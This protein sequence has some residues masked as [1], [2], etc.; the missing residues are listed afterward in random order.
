VTL[1]ES[2][3][4]AGLSLLILSAA[5]S[6]SFACTNDQQC[7]GER[8]CINHE[9]TAAPTSSVTNRKCGKDIDCPGEEVCEANQCR[10]P[11]GSSTPAVSSSKYPVEIKGKDGAPMRLVPAGKFIM[12]SQEGRGQIYLKDFYMDVYEVTKARFLTFLRHSGYKDG[13]GWNA[14]LLNQELGKNGGQL[15]HDSAA[16]AEA[17]A[18]CQYYGKRLPTDD[19]W[20]KAARGTDGRDYPWGDEDPTPAHAAFD[21]KGAPPKPVGSYEKGK[22]P[23]GLYDMAGNVAELVDAPDPLRKYRD[24][25]ILHLRGGSTESSKTGLNVWKTDPMDLELDRE[26]L[27][28]PSSFN[29]YKNAFDEKKLR[30]GFRCA[31]DPPK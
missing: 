18:Y 15:P 16:L 11:G 1:A 3:R 31:A 20:E 5:D 19:E 14:A 10:L 30:I 2:I 17:K 25:D 7:K 6:W 22:S 21:S 27:K 12:G 9:C 13:Y 4:T 24:S 28:D 23:Y 8:V 26:Y 29:P